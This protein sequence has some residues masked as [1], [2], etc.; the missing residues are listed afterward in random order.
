MQKPDTTIY[1]FDQIIDR[2]N[3][4]SDKWNS[5]DEDVLPMWV[6]DMDFISPKPVLDVLQARVEHGVF[7]YPN[8][9][10]SFEKDLPNIRA[11][12]IEHLAKTYGW[13]IETKDILLIPG[14][15][16]GFRQACLAFAQSDEAVLIQT[17]VYHPILNVAKTTG[18]QS[19]EMEMT[20]QANGT[21]I[22]D[23]DIFD[24][25]FNAQTRL[26]ILCNPHNPIGKVY[27]QAELERLA[28]TC[29]QNNV[30]ICSDEI[31]CDL[32]YQEHQHVPIATIDPEIAQNTITLIA[33]SKTYNLAGIHCSIAIIQNPEIRRNFRYAS[34]GLVPAVNLFGLAATQAAY[35]FGGPWLN[36]MLAYLRSN[37]DFLVNTI[38]HKLPG[39]RMAPPEG[40]YLG[41]LDCRAA[42]IEGNPQ[43]F[44]LEKA[45][46]A[47]NDGE[48]F[49]R[50]GEGFVRLNFGCPRPI[51]EEGLERMIKALNT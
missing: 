43:N 27:T 45:R 24:N 38:K 42:G 11:I 18:I 25:S 34:K 29:L 33:P 6:A 15:V 51:L 4:D 30:I 19:Q 40:T 28:Q 10:T 47:F 7:G 2:R 32:V 23:W 41:W 39:I 17:P 13:Q 9:N 26:F 1:D 49:G 20:L 48:T 37:R 5:Y 22:V 35:Q 36:Q 44:F 12:I 8:E 14:V 16:T 31:H 3:S 50:G 21:Y 46:V